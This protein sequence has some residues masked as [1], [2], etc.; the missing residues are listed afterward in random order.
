M[1][2]EDP[3]TE[4]Y[5]PA[6]HMEQTRVPVLLEKVPLTHVTQSE[7]EVPTALRAVPNGQSKQAEDDEEENFAEAQAIQSSKAS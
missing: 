3:E 5:C 4:T 1:H 2:A 6:P 7:M